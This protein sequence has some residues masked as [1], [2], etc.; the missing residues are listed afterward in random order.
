MGVSRRGV[1]LPGFSIYL[2]AFLCISHQAFSLYV[3]LASMGCIHTV[4][5]THGINPKVNVIV[6]L[7]FLCICVYIFICKMRYVLT[8]LPENT[9]NVFCWHSSTI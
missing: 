8:I 2:I 9:M 7:E 4:V 1:F 6:W 3:V 5:L